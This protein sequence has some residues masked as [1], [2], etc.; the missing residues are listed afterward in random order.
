MQSQSISQDRSSELELDKMLGEGSFGQVFRAR[1]KATGAI[2]AVKVVP[3]NEGDE[4]ADKIM[5]EIDILSKCNSPYIV[6]YFECFVC[7]PKKKMEAGEMWIVMEFCDGGSV[8]DLIEAAG[9]RGSF[10]MPEEAIRAACAGIVLGLEYL[11]KKEIC[12]RDIKCGNVLLTNDGHVKLADFGVSAELTNTINKRKTVVGSPFWIAPEVIKEAHYDGRADVWSLGITAI[13]MAEGAPPHSNLNPLRA[14][15]LI[16]SKPAPTL[17]DPDNWSPEM[18]DFI[19]CCCKKDPSERSDSALLTAH[20]FVRQEVLAL[21]R[22]HAGFEN[23]GHGA[24][25]YEMAAKMSKHRSPGLPALRAF[26]DRMR[27]P[28]DAVKS[29]R[30]MGFEGKPE[31]GE[32]G[33]PSKKQAALSPMSSHMSSGSDESDD[34]GADSSRPTPNGTSEIRNLNPPDWNGRGR[35]GASGIQGTV[36]SANGDISSDSVFNRTFKEI[37]PVLKQDKVFQDE[38]H[39]LNQ[40]YEAKLASL[41][42][43]HEESRRKIIISAMVRN[44]KGVDVKVLMESAAARR[45]VE[46]K[47]KNVYKQAADSECMKVMLDSMAPNN[48]A[49]RE[50]DDNNMV[51]TANTGGQQV[52]QEMAREEEEEA[53]LLNGVKFQDIYNR[54]SSKSSSK[55]RDGNGDRLEIMNLDLDSPTESNRKQETVF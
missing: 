12:H 45:D 36:P 55:S 46:L 8:S 31:G 7:P 25:G 40:L 19:R 42:A 37:D 1:H 27:N 17:A 44:R 16:P 22:M 54:T 15:F 4:E 53:T 41:K 20:P 39:K 23:C 30:D 24:S 47:S 14:I 48:N 11:H 28:L 32:G 26:M 29:Q 18:L 50:F 34:G 49:K 10:A 38:M 52:I 21:R 33:S 51:R 43:A 9:G 3:N 6:G 2:V 5:G 13:E 35:N